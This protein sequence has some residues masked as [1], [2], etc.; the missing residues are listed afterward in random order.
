M[1]QADGARIGQQRAQRG[2]GI[3][4][5]A[6]PRH[7]A[8]A[9]VAQAVRRQGVGARLPAQLDTAAELAVPQPAPV[10]WQPRHG[11]TGGQRDGR[12]LGL[13]VDQ[14]GEKAVG[15]GADQR[16]L[17]AAGFGPQVVGRPAALQG[18]D[19]AGQMFG[20]RPDELQCG[21]GHG[22][23]SLFFDQYERRAMPQRP[24]ACTT[25]QRLACVLSTAPAASRR[26]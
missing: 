14:A 16:Q 7:H 4:P 18:R 9:D 6:F 21:K 24:S 25:I 22:K 26:V 8:V 11:A 17:F 1:V 10:A 15:V 5:A 3:A 13:A 12:A 2:G 20:R 23:R 19:V